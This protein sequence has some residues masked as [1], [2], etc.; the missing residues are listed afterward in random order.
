MS[1]DPGILESTEM[2]RMKFEE[3]VVTNWRIDV[4]YLREGPISKGSLNEATTIFPVFH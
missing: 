3:I 2:R 1:L 4:D